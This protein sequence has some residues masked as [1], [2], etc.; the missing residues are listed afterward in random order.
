MSRYG[1]FLVP[2][3]VVTGQRFG[4]RIISLP[5]PFRPH[6]KGEVGGRVRSGLTLVVSPIYLKV[7]CRGPTYHLFPFLLFSLWGPTVLLSLQWIGER[8]HRLNNKR[9]RQ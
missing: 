6:M 5:L 4:S 3:G 9:S 8:I 2:H 7:A 1:S